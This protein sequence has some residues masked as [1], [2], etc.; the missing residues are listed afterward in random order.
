MARLSTTCKNQIKT[1]KYK[2]Q[3]YKKR[4]IIPIL[5]DLNRSSQTRLCYLQSKKLLIQLK[6]YASSYAQKGDWHFLLDLYQMK[7]DQVKKLNIAFP[8][9][10]SIK[11]NGNR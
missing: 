3:K 4:E 9:T 5:F 1:T 7:L 6:I 11:Q 2:K 8:T 10:I